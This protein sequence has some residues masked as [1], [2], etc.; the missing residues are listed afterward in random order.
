M[1]PT[2]IPHCQEYGRAIVR[3]CALAGRWGHE[4][5]ARDLERGAT[6]VV[7]DPNYRSELGQV[8]LRWASDH[9]DAVDTAIVI[10]ALD[11]LALNDA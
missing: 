11:R 5:T 3:R 9:G 4:L 7:S 1:S 6:A 10:E 8:A 2:D